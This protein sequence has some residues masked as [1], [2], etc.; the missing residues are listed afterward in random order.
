[1]GAPGSVHPAMHNANLSAL[2]AAEPVALS[3][4]HGKL[5]RNGYRS[6]QGK[7][8]CEDG[9]ATARDQVSN[10]VMRIEISRPGM[11]APSLAA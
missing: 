1:M 8:Y 2:I 6:T 10:A 3:A 5:R 9:D 4:G 11:S 7:D